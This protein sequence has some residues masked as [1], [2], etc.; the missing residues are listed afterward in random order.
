MISEM[1]Q[2]I[3][4][5]MRTHG[6][7]SVF[8]GVMIEQIIVPIPSPM[9]V[10]GAGAIL[11]RPGP[12][13]PECP[14]ADPLDH[15]PS[16]LHCFHS[17]FL[18][19]IYDQFLRRESAGGE[20]RTLLGCRLGGDRELGETIQSEEGGPEHLSHSGH[21]GLPYFPGFDLCRAPPGSAQALYLIH[22]LG[23]IFRCLFLGFVGWWIGAT[24][25][26]AATRFDSVETWISVLMLI[27]MFVGF[28][29]PLSQVQEMR[30]PVRKKRCFGSRLD[31]A[32]FPIYD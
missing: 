19:R 10:M 5:L 13:D 9:I 30:L 11:I 2:W 23:S 29:I 4:E 14:V 27:G 25:E 32:Q 6:Q 17:G 16:R 20:V 31:F 21:S 18:H 26:K 1:T 8:I 24:Y 12:F 22:F 15:C 7:V 3:M 28:R